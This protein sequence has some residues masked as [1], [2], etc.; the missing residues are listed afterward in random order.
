MT[1]VCLLDTCALLALQNGGKEFSR[2]TRTILEAPNSKVFISS[3]SAFEVGQK[4]ASGKLTL[5]RD[6]SDWFPA[7]LKQHFLTEIPVTSSIAA[8]ATTLPPI[9]R[10]PFDRIIIATAIESKLTIITS[11]RTIPTYPGILTQW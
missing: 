4:A 2:K 3:I 11:D 5:P 1:R 9:H 7:M 6:L 8:A 10:D